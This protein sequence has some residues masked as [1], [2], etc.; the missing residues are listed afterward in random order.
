M[1]TDIMKF[2][3]SKGHYCSLSGGIFPVKGHI[4]CA[5]ALCYNNE[6]ANMSYCPFTVETI[7]KDSITPFCP[8]HCLMFIIKPSPIE[9][10]CPG[11][12]NSKTVNLPQA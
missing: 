2:F 10:R 12:K 1:D 7:S 5:L 4:D 3:A 8:N 6:N 9:Y 11:Y